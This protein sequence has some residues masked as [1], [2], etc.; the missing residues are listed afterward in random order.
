[1]FLFVV[2]LLIAGGVIAYVGDRLG[3]Y[4]GKKRLSAWGLRPRH[5]ALLYTVLSGGLIAV[6]TLF[7][8]IGY[9]RAVQRALLYGPQILRENAHLEAQDR[10][11]SRLI[12]VRAAEAAAAAVRAQDALRQAAEAERRQRLVLGRLNVAQEALQQ[13]RGDLARRQAELQA[14]RRQFAVVS[15][16]LGATRA[17]LRQARAR[18][19]T[20]QEAVQDARDNV[21]V[22]EAQYGHALGTVADLARQGDVLTAR[23]AALTRQNAALA[24]RNRQLLTQTSFLQG[25]H[26]LFHKGQ[27]VGR[28][29]IPVGLPAAEVRRRLTSFLDDLSGIALSGGATDGGNGRAVRVIAQRAS[30]PPVSEGDA[31]DALA[32]SIAGEDGTARGVVVIA[33][34]GY[35]AFGGEQTPLLLQPY[36]DVLVYPKGAFIAQ[37]TIDGSLPEDRILD[38]LQAFLMDQVQP[39][40]RRR[41]VIP[42]PDP[43]TGEPTVGEPTDSDRTLAL[44]KQIQRLGPGAL[45]VAR[46][47]ADTDSSGPLRVDLSASPS[48]ATPAPATTSGLDAP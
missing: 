41:G 9:D 47:A 23:N 2:V 25:A 43:R 11:Q 24:A 39:D 38:A 48:P 28:R 5:T 18:L 30:G 7:T 31:L 8:L 35:N 22:A 19:Q 29:V 40:A 21:K 36:D 1:M 10:V 33:V 14:A 32:Q 20:A 27:E 3:T 16:G 46:A 4:I 26:L 45:V 12:R 34:A 17:T 42:R 37:T 15:A 6:L 44:V 13:S